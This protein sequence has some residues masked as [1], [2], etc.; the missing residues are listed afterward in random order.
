MAPPWGSVT[1]PEML[2]TGCCVTAGELK[3]MIANAVRT[4]RR[5]FP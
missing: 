1:I 2:P 5:N 4:N 3:A